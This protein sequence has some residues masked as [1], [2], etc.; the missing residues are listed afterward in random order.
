MLDLLR[1]SAGSL[2]N[3]LSPGVWCRW[4]WVIRLSWKFAAASVLADAQL[5]VQSWQ[6]A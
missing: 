4:P 6:A 3:L 5:P 2:L 1:A